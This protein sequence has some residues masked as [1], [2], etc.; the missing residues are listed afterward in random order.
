M[1][2]AG[3]K[4]QLSR[5]SFAASAFLHIELCALAWL[6]PVPVQLSLPQEESIEVDI[7]NLPPPGSEAKH[8]PA[9]A[10]LLPFK[11]MLSR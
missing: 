2:R 6:L 3:V 8:E 7:V 9:R 11:R 10:R 4:D 5:W 1:R